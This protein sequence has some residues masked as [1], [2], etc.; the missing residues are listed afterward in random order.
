M[1]RLLFFGDGD[2]VVNFADAFQGE[3]LSVEDLVFEG[4]D[5]NDKIENED[6]VIKNEEQAELRVIIFNNLLFI[7]VIS[8]RQGSKE[9]DYY[10][11]LRP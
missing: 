1:G 6:G 3:D 9:A 2:D 7:I 11:L 8:R 10:Y 5:G 4:E